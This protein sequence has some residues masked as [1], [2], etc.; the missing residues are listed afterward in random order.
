MHLKDLETSEIEVQTCKFCGRRSCK[1]GLSEVPELRPRSPMIQQSSCQPSTEN[2]L[3]DLRQLTLQQVLQEKSAV[4]NLRKP[5]QAPSS[6]RSWRNVLQPELE[7]SEIE[8]TEDN[9]SRYQR[10]KYEFSNTAL[11]LWANIS[12]PSLVLTVTIAILAILISCTFAA[13]VFFAYYL[14]LF[15]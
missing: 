14:K 7:S 11:K 4:S 9:D 6:P 15:H 5:S 10:E 13:S 12:P 2:V 8:S 3:G 1:I